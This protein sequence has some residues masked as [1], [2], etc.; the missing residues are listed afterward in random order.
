MR[1]LNSDFGRYVTRG[2]SI[3]LITLITVAAIVSMVFIGVSLREAHSLEST[4]VE[5]MSLSGSGVLD[6]AE[7]AIEHVSSDPLFR[8]NAQDGTVFGPLVVDKGGNTL[9]STVVDAATGLKPTYDTAT[10]RVNVN[11]VNGIANASAQIDVLATPTDYLAALEQLKMVHYWPLNEKT[12]STLALDHGG[13]YDGTYLDPNVAGV[14]HNDDGGM[15][16]VFAS[17]NDYVEVPYGQD[18][19]QTAGAISVWIKLTATDKT[20]HAFMGTRWKNRERSTLQYGHIQEC[21]ERLF[22]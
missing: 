10:Y 14:S 13:A 4:L 19:K 21:S 16:P 9:S 1:E 22:R 18:F 3:Y 8:V 7:L 20:N 6:A 11:S 5:Q 15:V 17:W 2:G 12:S